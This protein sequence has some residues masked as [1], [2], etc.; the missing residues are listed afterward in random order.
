MAKDLDRMLGADFFM[1]LNTTFFFENREGAVRPTREDYEDFYEAMRNFSWE[2]ARKPSQPNAE[3]SAEAPRSDTDTGTSASEVPSSQRE[4]ENYAPPSMYDLLGFSQAERSQ[5]TV[6]NRGKRVSASS[7]KGFKTSRSGFKPAGSGSVTSRTGFKSAG[8]DF[9]TSRNDFKPTGSDSVTSRSDSKPPGTDFTPRPYSQTL[10]EH[11]KRGSLVIDG[12]IVGYLKERY[13]TEA[14]FVALP[15]EAVP[16]AKAVAYV[17]LRDAYH[18]LYDYE[19]TEL[20]GNPELRASLNDLYDGF[21]KKYGQLNDRKNSNFIKTDAG[22]SEILALERVADGE[23]RKA[24]IF[25]RPVAFNPNEVTEVANPSE[26]LSASLNKYGEVNVEY[27]A[28]LV[29]SLTAGEIVRDLE[30]RIYYN[31]LAGNYEAADRFVA[32][33]V[34]EKAEAVARYMEEHPDDA[35]AVEAAD[36][37][38]ALREAVPEPVPFAELD[39]N[40]GERWI[41]T[42]VYSQYASYLFNTETY[43][44]YSGSGDEYSVKA[45]RTNANIYDKYAVSGEFRRFDGLV[46]MKHALHNTTPDITKSATATDADGNNVTVKV[47]DGE[48]IQLAGSKIEEIRNGFTEWLASGPDTVK[49]ELCRIYNGK[50]NSHVRPHYDGSCQ[51]F[52]GLDLKAL[53]IEDLYQSQ[54][55]AIWMLKANGGGICDHEVGSGKTLVMCCAAMEMKRLGLANKPMIIALKANVH[56]IARTFR[57]AYPDARIL[58]PGKADF[59]P[60]NRVGIFEAIKNNDWDAVILTH[61]QF[62]MIPQSPEIRQTILRAELDAVEENLEVLRAQGREV[63][64]GMLKGVEKRK[65]NLEVKLSE[66]AD[67]I[68]ERKDEVTD[69]GRMGIDH[70]FVDESH[71]F[72]NLMFTT[73]H[74]RVSGMGNPDGSQRALNL[75]FAIRTVQERTGKDLGATFLSGTT[76]SNSL[77]ELYLLFKYLRP[78][79][80]ERQ[81]ITTFDAWAAVFA[82][83]SA[84]YEFSVTNEIVRKERFR[85][86]IKVPELASFYAE[87]TDF[88]TAKDV[89]LD[90]PEKNEILHNIPLTP[91][92]EVFV[93]RLVEFAKTGDA[94]LLGR[95]SLTDKEEKA[96]MLIATDYAR[97]MSLDMR[98]PLQNAAHQFESFSDCF[99]AKKIQWNEPNMGIYQME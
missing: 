59:S 33:N 7:G 12:G 28:S 92:Q 93:G 31:P 80:L 36:S 43:V 19:A 18:R 98:R 4:S 14:V 26:A 58:Y 50:F 99:F 89:G 11:H 62:G 78:K 42:A 86:F 63:S 94:K 40:F 27:M 51:T 82:K 2:T 70:I 17:S 75:L 15:P 41:P 88:R 13:R 8:S 91:D 79:E 21:V 67:R 96:R 25:S 22:A 73:R 30:G 53:G 81:N 37:L 83:K 46:L 44:S 66:L 24:D 77:T 65:Q 56:E 47:R 74:D 84:D 55:D 52:P 60:K 54:K 32:G 61:D 10:L 90:R 85:H 87:I 34:A 95:H 5:I 72:K 3:P 49:D 69:F 20:R 48:K 29:P 9:V 97:K 39:F 45:M 64:R 6:K 35:R 38:R 71:R 23:F 1:K 68:K 76:V 16:Q 57:T